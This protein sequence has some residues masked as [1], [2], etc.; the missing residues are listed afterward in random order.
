MLG[1]VVTRHVR[2]QGVTVGSRDDFL[3]MSAAIARHGM[4]PVVDR[5]FPFDALHEALDYLASG[6]HFG[7]V[8]VRI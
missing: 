8:C 7:K 3:A 6:S 4:R 1:I 5:V 2:L